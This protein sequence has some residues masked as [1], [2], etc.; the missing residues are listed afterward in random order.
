[1]ATLDA[2][3]H[4]WVDNASGCDI[5]LDVTQNFF[6][7]TAGTSDA[8]PVYA[9]YIYKQGFFGPYDV[10]GTGGHPV[11]VWPESCTGI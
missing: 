10:Y 7:F 6:L 3:M 1:M 2:K 8:D 9:I 4:I 5:N 11:T